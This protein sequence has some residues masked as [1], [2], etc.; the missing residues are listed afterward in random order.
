MEDSKK[1][2]NRARVLQNSVTTYNQSRY[3]IKSIDLLYKTKV[4]FNFIQFPNTINNN[5]HCIKNKKIIKLLNKWIKNCN[6]A[7]I[8]I[9]NHEWWK[10]NVKCIV[11]IMHLTE[12]PVAIGSGIAPEKI[13][14][15][16]LSC[17]LY[18]EI[19]GE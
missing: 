17:L 11:F 3:A 12:L 4:N 19:G 13:C 15:F 2:K 14:T 6:R 8:K 7:R 16:V 5:N 10:E 1:K 18:R 9:V